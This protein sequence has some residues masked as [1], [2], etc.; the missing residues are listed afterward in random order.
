MRPAPLL[1]A[2]LFTAAPTSAAPWVEAGS[3][4]LR[5]DV[6]RLAAAGA[7]RGPINAWP[8]PAAQ[9]CKIGEVD[10]ALADAARRIAA[11]C[12]A[13]GPRLTSYVTSEPALIRGFGTTARGEGDIAASASKD[14]GR[15]NLRFGAGMRDGKAHL[16]PTLLTLDYG[17]WA[18]YGG[19]VD[20]WWGPGRE[21]ALLLSTN[22]RPTP[23]I[24]FRRTAPAPIDLPVLRALGPVSVEVFA[25]LLT[26]DRRDYKNTAL[27]AMR[28]AFAPAPGLEIGLNRALQLCGQNRPC[29]LNMLADAII[30]FG[31]RDN[32]G[33]PNE[34]GNQLAGGDV[35]YRTMI[36][37]VAAQVYAEIEG[38]DEN[39]VIV[40]QF[41]RVAG[42]A[43][44]GPAG[45]DGASWS[46]HGEAADTLATKLFGG[47]KRY[48]GSFYN[49]SIYTDGYRYR[50][51]S[52]GSSLDGDGR[53]WALAGSYTDADD[54]RVYATWRK[55]ELNR[56]G[57][58]RNPI[59]LVP[60]EFHL[61]T[62][63]VELPAATGRLRL[64][65]RLADR[66]AGARP[67]VPG[68][69]VELSFTLAR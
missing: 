67:L 13:D 33:T 10:A 48:P 34:P 36:G 61:L 19:F 37:P 57:T 22:A 3:E 2:L 38:E 30:A 65:G 59:T 18:I 24:G 44:T 29:D 28:A 27:V 12:A 56:S 54:R 9:L 60:A 26:G 14:F 15:I 52:L 55:V 63:G 69:A 46:L 25:G 62:A 16:E 58:A 41:G 5:Q 49:H 7:I 32:S 4:Q 47:G 6:D 53:M 43:L 66:D 39:N 17:G 35:S 8:L 23:Q 31:D 11:A 50:G 42:F 21:N 40:E 45:E 51:R 20:H 68:A 1:A 64:E